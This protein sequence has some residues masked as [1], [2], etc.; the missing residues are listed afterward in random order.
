MPGEIEPLDPAID[1]VRGP[2]GA[3]LILEYGDFECP[4][5]RRAFREIARVEQRLDGNVRFAFRHFPLTHKHPHAWAA[6][7]AAEAAASQT[8]FWE[9]YDLLFPNQSHLEESDLLGYAEQLELDAERFEHD[10][11]GL[12]VRQ[13]ITRDI[14]SGLASGQVHGTPTLFIAGSL[15]EGNYDADTLIE[16]LR[17]S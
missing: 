9:M 17:R 16:V 13:R 14:E 12:P 10:R 1:H 4:F 15:H 2:D 8:R 11:T 7:A 6:A 5:S 3:P